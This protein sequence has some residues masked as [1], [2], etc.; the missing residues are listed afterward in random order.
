MKASICA[1]VGRRFFATDR[2]DLESM[3][4]AVRNVVGVR[5]VPSNAIAGRDERSPSR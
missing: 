3:V 5:Y 1:S 2:L 4:S